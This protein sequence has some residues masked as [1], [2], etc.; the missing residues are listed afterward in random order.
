[1]SRS[2]QIALG[3]FGVSAIACAAFALFGLVSVNRFVEQAASF[4]PEE[5]SRPGLAWPRFSR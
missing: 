1:V 3:V 2:A 5:R 4:T